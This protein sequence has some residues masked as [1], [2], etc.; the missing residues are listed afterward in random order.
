MLRHHSLGPAELAALM[1]AWRPRKVVVEPRFR[2]IAAFDAKVE[3]HEADHAG[4][5]AARPGE[6]GKGARP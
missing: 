3:E 6:K 1:S 5:L 2:W 4:P